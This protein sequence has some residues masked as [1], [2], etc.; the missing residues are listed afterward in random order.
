MSFLSLNEFDAS[1]L[2]KDIHFI[3]NLI[4]TLTDPNYYYVII[5]LQK[6]RVELILY[7]KKG[8]CMIAKCNVIFLLVCIAMYCIEYHFYFT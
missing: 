4:K 7:K 1:L 5:F 8:C 3:K 2:N 6:V